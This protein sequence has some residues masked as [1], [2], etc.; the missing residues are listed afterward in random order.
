M[1][2]VQGYAVLL[3]LLALLAVMFAPFLIILINAIKTPTDL[4]AN[5]PLSIPTSPT[6]DNISTFWNA[7]LMTSSTWPVPLVRVISSV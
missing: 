6:L 5:G 2:G 1:G 3:C 7:A 4:A